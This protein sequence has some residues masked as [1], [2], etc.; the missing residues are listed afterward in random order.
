VIFNLAF[1]FIWNLDFGIW[2]FT[3][4]NLFYYLVYR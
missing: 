2:N 1:E 4:T 3:N